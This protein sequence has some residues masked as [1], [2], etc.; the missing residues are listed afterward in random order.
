MKPQDYQQAAL[1]TLYP[2]LTTNERLGLCG[3]GMAGETGEV[4]DMLKKYLYH[5]NGKPLDTQKLKDEL[6]DVLWYFFVLLDTVGLTFEQ[7]MEATKLEQT[8]ASGLVGRSRLEFCGLE[9]AG[10]L[11]RVAETL[12]SAL[13]QNIPLDINELKE[14]L[15]NVLRYFLVLLDTLGITFEQAMEANVIKL[16]ARHA[17]GFNA[18]YQSDSGASA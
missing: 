11:G 10:N 4:A 2:D 5:R 3:L 6:G 14:R 8:I 13:Y 16:E 7:V 9:L 17:S 12:C 1:R 18:R 15:G